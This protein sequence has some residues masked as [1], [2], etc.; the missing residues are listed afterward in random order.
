[1]KKL[2]NK[3]VSDKRSAKIMLWILTPL[4]LPIFVE[5][6]WII[7]GYIY[8]F[9]AVKIIG[10]KYTGAVLL[11]AFLTSILFAIATYILLYKQYKKHIIKE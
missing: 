11:I 3:L 4:L 2:T 7:F 6:Y 9:I 5:F 10:Y 8:G 1:M